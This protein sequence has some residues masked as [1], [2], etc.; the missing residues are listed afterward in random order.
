MK[1]AACS[2]LISLPR[3]KLNHMKLQCCLLKVPERER[4]SKKTRS[5]PFTTEN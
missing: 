2:M 4:G 1:H 5:L 3:I